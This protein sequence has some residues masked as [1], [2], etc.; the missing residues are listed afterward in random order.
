MV[1]GRVRVS[2]LHL[3]F[4]HLA[5]LHS[6][7]FSLHL[8]SSFFFLILTMAT[9]PT[10]TPPG[11][12]D[13]VP[14]IHRNF[15]SSSYHHDW[16]KTLPKGL[17]LPAALVLVYP[18][19]PL[20]K[21]TKKQEKDQDEEED[22]LAQALSAWLEE[23]EEEKEEKGK[24]YVWLPNS[25]RRLHPKK[26]TNGKLKKNRITQPTQRRRLIHQPST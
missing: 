13:F 14:P 18:P 25:K 9:T 15:S 7:I 22:G 6:C 11:W 5:F 3:A 2:F 24:R 16:I 1:T 23:K 4:L 20:Q 19:P 8:P 10:T 17:S 26:D 12:I 21:T